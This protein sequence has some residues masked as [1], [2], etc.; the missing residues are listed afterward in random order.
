MLYSNISEMKKIK[1]CIV[2]KE[3]D[4]FCRNKSALTAASAKKICPT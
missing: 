4:I 1:T 2:F 3:H